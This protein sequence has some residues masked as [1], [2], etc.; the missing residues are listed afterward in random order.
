MVRR[1]SEGPRR[2][3]LHSWIYGI[4]FAGEVELGVICVPMEINA[5]FL[6]D[7]AKWEEIYDE[8]K[9]LQDRALG[10]TCSDLSECS[11]RD[12]I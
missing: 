5:V 1:V 8:K 2:L 11:Q 10:H 7:I 4:G 6:E 3:I 12:E 9:G